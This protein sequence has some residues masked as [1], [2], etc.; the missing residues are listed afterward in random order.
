MSDPAPSSS[1]SATA[2]ADLRIPPQASDREAAAIAAAIGAHLRD[3]E[4]TATD[5]DRD[6][7]E[8]IAEP[9]Q[10]R[11]WAF[12]GRIQ[13]LQGRAVRPARGAPPSGWA[14]AGRTDRMR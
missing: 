4:T 2:P 13:Q 5:D 1:Q 9:W 7:G 10:G 6:E 14:A 12:A 8:A 11:R 3:G